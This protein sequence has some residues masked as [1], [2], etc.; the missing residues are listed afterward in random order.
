[1]EEKIGGQESMKFLFT[2]D[3]HLSRYGQDK[4]ES[5]SNLPERLHSI[6]ETLHSMG[7]YCYDNDIGLFVIGG[8]IMHNKSIIYSMAQDLMLGFFEQY[9]DLEF[10]VLDGNHDLSGKGADAISSLRCLHSVDN[11]D[12]VN[13]SPTGWQDMVSIPYSYDVANQ[14][15]TG[16][17]KILISHFGLDEGMLNSGISITSDISLSDLIGKYELVLLGHYHK[18][19][20]IIRDDIRLYYVGSPIQLDWGEK[21]DEKRFLIVDTDTLDVQSIPTV[22]YKKHIEIEI[23][24]SNKAEVL[25][26]ATQQKESGNYVKL[27]KTESVEIESD[28]FSVIDKT[29]KDIT[30]RGITSTMSE[31]DKLNRFMEIKEIPSDKTERFLNAGLEIINSCEEE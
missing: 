25:I 20:E 17:R 14:V 5:E 13:R 19:Q 15:K 27:I 11:V 12:W 2:A 28:Q 7:D 21:G 9:E 3:I 1:L 23:N 22:G 16:K 24:N 26:E 8:D 10:S 18:P 31:R 29:D 6:K 4:I 30:N